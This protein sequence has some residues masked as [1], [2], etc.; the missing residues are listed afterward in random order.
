MKVRVSGSYIE[1]NFK[2]LWP[3]YRFEAKFEKYSWDAKLVKLNQKLIKHVIYN[4][5][6]Q[7]LFNYF[8]HFF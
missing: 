5:S 1:T 2:D 7:F 3:N 6:I 4:G 8:H